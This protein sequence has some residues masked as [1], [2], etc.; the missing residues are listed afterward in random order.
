MFT[1]RWLLAPPGGF[2]DAIAK[3]IH[4][5]VGHAILF[6]VHFHRIVKE[7]VGCDT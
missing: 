1:E 7:D 6:V 2:I 4:K 5:A 3:V